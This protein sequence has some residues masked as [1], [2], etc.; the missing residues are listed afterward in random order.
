MWSHS[1]KI[2][3][4]H[5]RNVTSGHKL[6]EAGKAHSQLW[7][8]NPTICIYNRL[9]QELVLHKYTFYNNRT[10]H[11]KYILQEKVPLLLNFSCV[12]KKLYIIL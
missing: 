8:V 10:Y 2:M 5:E 6:A 7:F 12:E 3:A 4:L 11:S 1:L 9:H